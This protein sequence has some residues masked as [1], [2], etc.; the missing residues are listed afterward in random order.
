MSRFD[1]YLD[2]RTHHRPSNR[3]IESLP[4]LLLAADQKDPH[5]ETFVGLVQFVILSN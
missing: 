3:L 2:T 4:L 5:S 1:A